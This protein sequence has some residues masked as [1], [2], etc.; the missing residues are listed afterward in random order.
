MTRI[1][2][3]PPLLGDA[4]RVLILGSVPSVASLDK[5]QYYGKA[6]NA[7]WRIM[8]ELFSAAPELDYTERCRRLTDA[9]IVVWDVLASCV[10]PGSLDSAIDMQTTEV[11]DLRGL[12][13]REAG[14]N[15]VFFNGR[16]AEEIFMRR[17]RIDIDQ[18]RS[19]IIYECL[20]STSPAMAT[21]NFEQKL[22]SWKAVLW[23]ADNSGVGHTHA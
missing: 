6:Q 9:G 17:L 15:H 22:S 16:K 7:F 5:Q 3:F 8:G 2:G 12:L 10:R 11:N 23:A 1:K 4:P 18:F 21:L 14:I 20:P 13:A 19:E